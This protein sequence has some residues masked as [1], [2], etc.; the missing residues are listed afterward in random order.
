MPRST[1]VDHI[2]WVPAVNL[3]SNLTKAVSTPACA[4]TTTMGIL[5][6]TV[7]T[8]TKTSYDITGFR[9]T[10][11]LN[12]GGKYIG[13]FILRRS[14]STVIR[15]SHLS[16]VQFIIRVYHRYDDGWIRV[17]AQDLP[18]ETP[19]TQKLILEYQFQQSPMFPCARNPITPPS[20]KKFRRILFEY[21]S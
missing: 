12:S 20:L 18:L 7:I 19:T 16:Y 6:S 14:A 5:Q 13:S 2:P 9:A 17:F 3:D 1:S 10:P 8:Y 21:N 11:T 4:C 15:V